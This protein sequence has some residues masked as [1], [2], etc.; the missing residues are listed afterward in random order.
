V[1][2]EMLRERGD[3]ERERDRLHTQLQ[4]TYTVSQINMSANFCTYLHQ[5][6]THC[7]NSFTATLE[8]LQ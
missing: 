3:I 7:K 8:N 1:R 2:V 4:G 6:S 5:I